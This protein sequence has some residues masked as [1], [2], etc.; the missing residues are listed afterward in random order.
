VTPAARPAS[1]HATR[2]H[3]ATA[4][5]ANTTDVN[6]PRNTLGEMRCNSPY[7]YALSGIWVNA[8]SL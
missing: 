2:V 8:K 4:P 3:S 1:R 6:R 7:A 5:T